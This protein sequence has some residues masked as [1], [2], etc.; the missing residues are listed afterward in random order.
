MIYSPDGH[1]RAFDANSKGVVG[2]DGAGVVVMKRNQQAAADR[3]HIYAIIKGSAA[4]NDGIRKVGYTAPSVEGQAEVIRAAQTAAAVEPE[5]ITY[6][7]AHGTGTELGDPVEVEAL[8]MVFN[9]GK[10]NFC[11]I[12]S[13][14]T[15]LGHLDSAAGAAS[16]IKVVLALQH[17]QIPP[18]LHFNSPNPKLGLED[19]PFYVVSKLTPWKRNSFP[20][21]AGVSSLGI[22]GTNAHVVLEE[23]PGD[24]RQYS[25]KGSR[26]YQLLLLSAKTPQ[27]LERI[28][29]NLVSHFKENP[30]IDPADA[31][32]TLQVGRTPFPYRTITLSTS[33][34]EAVQNLS[35][36]S[37]KVRTSLSKEKNPP[38]IFIFS[39]Q[40][41][42]YV[43]MGRDLYEK[44]PLFRE[45]IHRCFEML[46]PIPG[47]DIK[48]IMYPSN[49]DNR[50]NRTYIN[51][52]KIIQTLLFIFEYALAKLLMKWGIQP[53]A[54][55]GYSLGEYTAACISGVFSLE[56]ALKTVVSRGGLIEETPAGAMLSVP[57]TEKEIKPLLN[58]H[59]KISLAIV[60]GPSCI[61][62][63]PTA[64]IDAFEKE[65]KQKRLLCTR[66]NISHAV[67]S[68]LMRP[69]REKFKD[70][71]KAI[72]LDKPLIPFISN[73]SGD[74]LTAA[75]AR[76]PGYWAKQMCA[77]VR[78]S[79]GLDCLCREE[80]AVFIE[81]G[82]G[83]VLSNIIRQHAQ[84]KPGQQVV[85]LVR[86]QQEKE[87]D[88]YFLLRALGQLWLYGVD[89][90]WSEFHNGEARHR[91]SL[92]TYPF[93][94]QR[95]WIEAP[96]FA[97]RTGA[98][99][100][101]FMPFTGLA[102]Q[103]G[104]Y[105]PSWKPTPIP[106]APSSKT[107]SSAGSRHLCCVLFPDD[108]DRGIDSGL[109]NKIV[110]NGGEV[111][112]VKKGTQFK[113]EN[114]NMFSISPGKSSHYDRLIHALDSRGQLPGSFFYLWNNNRKSPKGL[115]HLIHLARSIGK[116][117]Y[118]S[119]FQFIVV[120]VNIQKVTED[121]ALNPGKAALLGPLL[122]ISHEYP[123]ISC[124]SIDIDNEAETLY[125][126]LQAEIFANPSDTVV[127]YRDNQRLVRGFE[128][129]PPE[130]TDSPA[131]QDQ[132]QED[133][134]R[135][136]P[137]DYVAPR[138]ALEQKIT[139][140][141][142]EFL[143][144]E[145]IGIHDNFFYLNG[146]SLTATQLITRVKEMYQVEIPMQDFFEDPTIAHLAQIVKKLLVEKIK[147]LSP[148]E[149][150]KLLT[151]R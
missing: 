30:G 12:G 129:V 24:N 141:W 106:G 11:A 125:Q 143:G 132:S 96:R 40:G 53:R 67:H 97:D 113:K 15:N 77:P 148:E 146:D 134:P 94:G 108:Q 90:N 9:T 91:I 144:F 38:V 117:N 66:I 151:T 92:P 95:Y 52:T 16:F 102:K 61:V 64:A 62:A 31:A 46:K 44:E 99:P 100:G 10:K 80:H 5:S 20:L 57:L 140:L 36:K 116:R 136:I 47:H 84:K 112:I 123:E 4:N 50:S 13:V 60:N 41:S 75:Q 8:K 126:Q 85:N 105:L 43:N 7:E 93:E 70:K 138:D 79:Q 111:V 26:P 149:K 14:K 6:L 51:Q 21:R 150:K 139:G 118:Q 69:I 128:P 82:P 133:I 137:G 42:Q 3:D 29:T 58:N 28:T 59:K 48:E 119:K 127:A 22:G 17:H 35:Q 147:N 121:K 34:E 101:R 68:A 54:M 88:D 107:P 32:Y 104:A 1:C 115:D 23:Y 130:E 73:I 2:G 142:Q 83:R 39:G 65:M 145:T 103:D 74:W 89:I 33:V 45:E 110:Q 124:R 27:A 72:T 135:E 49:Q 114:H 81:I 56:D 55:M 131:P 19:S 76:D 120:S 98:L 87:S 86:H 37:G 78:F 25:S 18:S 71:V 109:V 122:A 63:G